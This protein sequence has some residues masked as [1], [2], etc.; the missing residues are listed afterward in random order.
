MQSPTFATATVPLP[1]YPE[2][3]NRRKK[4]Q[5]INRDQGGEGNADH[6]VGVLVDLAGTRSTSLPH[7]IVAIPQT[8]FSSVWVDNA[9]PAAV[10][11]GAEEALGGKRQ[12][13]RY[14]LACSSSERSP[15]EL[16]GKQ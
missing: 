10:V 4:K 6:G 14:S 8:R 16:S 9:D 11:A 13:A 2:E 1:K 12:R 7:A 5:Q 15:E 3:K